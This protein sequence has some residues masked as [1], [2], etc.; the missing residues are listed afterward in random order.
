MLFDKAIVWLLAKRAP[1][2][3]L[4]NFLPCVGVSEHWNY[5]ISILCN[6]VTIPRMI[7]PYLLNITITLIM[8]KIDYPSLGLV[9]ADQFPAW[10]WVLAW[11]GAVSS[12]LVELDQ[13]LVWAWAPAWL[14]AVSSPV[15]RL[16]QFPW[17]WFPALLGAV[18]LP[19]LILDESDQPWLH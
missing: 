16:D 13:F 10:A 2:K 4:H 17:V 7:A 8:V 12:P 11:L 1:L 6:W 19:S 18:L 5:L 9:G 15:V 3:L 14:G